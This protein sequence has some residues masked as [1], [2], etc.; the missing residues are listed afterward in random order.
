MKIL[1]KPAL[2]GALLLTA[3]TQIQAADLDQNLVARWTFKG[4]SLKSDIGDF[5]LTDGGRG[6]SE[7]GDGQVTVR[8]RGYLLTPDIN[9]A[10]FPELKHSV[11]IWARLKFEEL[12][13]EGMIN[14]MGLLTA[15]DAGN[16]DAISLC[17]LYR[18]PDEQIVNPGFAF[19]ARPSDGT[20]LGVG[21]SRMIPANTGEFINVA[22]VYDGA[23]NS[24]SMWING[25]LANSR[26]PGAS[27]L[28]D[29]A[30]FAIGQL[31]SPGANIAVTF[32][33][34]RIYSTM[35][36]ENWLG[37]ITPVAD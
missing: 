32:D 4:G 15:P 18:G 11:T 14:L 19:L 36:D 30:A 12:P 26:R 20:E 24:S 6:S 22:I 1:S 23:A 25:Q 10:K 5:T 21:A 2:A 17:L 8:D 27:Q 31:K 28:T 7:I 33:E 9:L 3:I 16:W 35:L 37:E 29:F 34:V 13:Q